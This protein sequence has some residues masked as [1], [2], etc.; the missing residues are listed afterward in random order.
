MY[1]N[2]FKH[3]PQVC[4]TRSYCPNIS[5]S[6]LLPDQKRLLWKHLKE[7]FPEKAQSISQIV[8]DPIALELIN[9]FGAELLLEEKYVPSQL[10]WLIRK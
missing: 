8:D 3:W 9:K 2:E 4:E 1:L 5:I 10:R 7:S 6:A